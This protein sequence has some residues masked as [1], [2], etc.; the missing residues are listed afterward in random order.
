[1]KRFG[2]L[3]ALALVACLT[4]AGCGGGGKKTTQTTKPTATLTSISVASTGAATSVAAGATLQLTATGHYSDGT[5]ATLTSVSWASSDGTLA[6]LSVSGMLTALKAG[7]VTVTATKGAVS[8]NMVINVTQ[9]TLSS[10]AVSGGS[11]LAAGSTEQLTAQGTYSDSTTGSLTTQATWQSS[12]ATVATVSN[13]GLL[14]AL[15]AGSVTV[16]A[17]MGSVSGTASVVVN[18]VSVSSITISP[19]LFSIASGQ[20]QQLTAQAVYPDGTSQ[21]VTSQVTWSS[22]ATNVAT[23]SGTG[24]V[25]GVSAG[26]STITATLGSVSRTAVATV[27]A[28]QLNSIIVTP[29]TASIATGQTQAF[30]ANGIFSDGSST[31]ITN[32]VAWTSSAISFVTIDPT[33]LGTG[34]SAGTATV[35]ATSGTVSGTA[36]LTVT[37]AVLNSIDIAP[38]DQYIPIGGQFPLVLTGSYSD[39]TTQTLTNA[40]WSSSDP[41]IASVDP[42]SGVVTGVSDSNGNPVTITATAD[43][44]SNTTS[45]YITA[46]VAESLTLTPTTSSIASGTTQQY[47]VDAIYSDGSIQP[48]TAGLSW[49]SSSAS[50][51]SISA[52]GLATGIA[53]GQSTITVTYG[54]M[55][56]TATLTVTPATLTSIVVTPV[57][58][59]VGV[60]G[61]VQFTATGVFTDNSTQDLSSQAAWSSSVASVAL[62]SNTG[63]AT[64]LSAGATTITANYGGLSGSA[65]LNVSTATLISITVTPA[66]PIVPP[67]SKIQLTATGNFSD[68]SHLVLS[69]V[70][71]RTSSAKYAMVSGSGV[72]RTKK[73]SNKVV[74]V[75][76]SLNGITGTTQLTITSMTVQSLSL[77]PSN[78]TMAVGTTQPFA[79]I[80]TFSD[81]VTTVDLTPSARWQTSNY[82][83]AVI[84]RSGIATGLGAGSVTIT[85]SYQNLTPATTTL[86]VSNATIQSITVTPASPTIA[87]GS[88][89]QFAAMGLFSDGSTQDITAVSQWT[90]STPTVAVMNKTG[91]AFSATHGQTNINATYKGTTGTTLLTVN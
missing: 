55:S 39:N 65:T 62:I 5:T 50:T 10:I 59:V 87:L 85:G 74:P 34:V 43:G 58:T 15:Q 61:N 78:A 69:G 33:G 21:D 64:G 48:L 26:T 49:A 19:A 57:T 42:V 73:S 37:A 68:G 66:N 44:M 82:H 77:T 81:G 52:L 36:S 83:Y 18:A 53:A 1:M 47:S 11:S 86:T 67:H 31:D 3:F 20:N 91:R 51:A 79:L 72:V 2:A 46:A 30:A 7:S 80:G 56:A 70:S 38:D 29:A 60:K 16:T 8:G 75:S 12:D 76:A 63:L 27:T 25:S 22:S 54:S 14:T 28:A 84:N 32:S 4:I 90:S 13:S 24:L 89:Q 45:V 88:M 23:V 40:V 9:A 35:T 17:T 6:S 71:W 41:T